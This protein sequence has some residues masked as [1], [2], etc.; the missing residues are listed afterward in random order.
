M[1]LS[2]VYDLRERLKSGAAAGTGLIADDFRLQRALDSLAPL[3]GAAPVFAKLGQGV[4]A[5]LDP[6]CPD[7]AAALLDALSLADA[8]LCTQAQVNAPCEITP[9][10]LTIEGT[11]AIT[12]AP[13]S[14]LNPLVEALTTSG[15]G[16]YSFAVDTYS[17]HPELFR[18]YR[19][20]YALVTALNAPYAELADQVADWLC[21][22]DESILPLLMRDFDPKGKR[23]MVRRIHVMEAVA[24][25]KANDFYK[26]LLETAEKDVRAAA[27]YALRHDETNAELLVTLTKTEKGNAKKQA[28][29]ALAELTSDTAWDFWENL[30]A[31]KP[32]VVAEYMALSTTE[33]ASELIVSSLLRCISVFESPD[34]VLTEE[35]AEQIQQLIQV[36]PGK[37]GATVG[38]FFRQAAALD[39]RLDKPLGEEKKA[40]LFSSG[41]WRRMAGERVFSQIL[42]TLLYRCLAFRPTLDLLALAEEMAETY[43]VDWAVP[44]IE[45]ALLT[46]PAAEAYDLMD[47]LTGSLL[48]KKLRR[49]VLEDVLEGLCW[50]KTE[51]CLVQKVSFSNPR[52]E[53]N[54]E[55]CQHLA[56]PLDAR[57]YR[58]LVKAEGNHEHL[59]IRIIQP[60]QEES[61]E[62]MMNHFYQ[63][64]LA[65][66]SGY[67]YF[68]PLRRLGCQRCEGLAVAFCKFQKNLTF[69][70][71]RNFF[72]QI[73]AD[74]QE[75]I[76]EAERLLALAEEGKIT[77]REKDA[78]DALR[79]MTLDL[80]NALT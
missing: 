22:E 20:K 1:D 59:L 9:I 56:E 46:K 60:A 28:H 13:Y 10:A 38:A 54:L 42:P 5:L 3:E 19:V 64:A 52:T 51:E 29:W 50:D 8:V 69:W 32:E 6:A 40:F 41:V 34:A 72:I 7:R 67:Q 65:G 75:K 48:H 44:A 55:I 17:Q 2:P 62:Y 15:S 78:L 66:S 58:A 77:F 36:L 47:K 43:G 14:L 16:R 76:A 27:V 12:D 35:L 70:S 61:R 57:W 24:G 31:K 53:T 39:H 45:G 37:S 26:S 25:A 18:D 80:K 30:G 79:K 74:Q 63:R 21:K 68:E 73:P 49:A 71:L 4:R 11:A 33:K 23:D